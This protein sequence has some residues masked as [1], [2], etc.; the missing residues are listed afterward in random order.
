MIK[1]GISLE[2]ILCSYLFIEKLVISA[3]CLIG[4]EHSCTYRCAHGWRWIIASANQPA[5]QSLNYVLPFSGL[6]STI[7]LV[8]ATD[9]LIIRH[10]VD[11]NWRCIRLLQVKQLLEL[12]ELPLEA[13]VWEDN[14]PSL[15]SKLECF[16]EHHVFLLHEVCD[17]AT[18]AAAHASVTVDKNAALRYALLDEGNGGRKVPNQARARRVRDGDHFVLQVLRKERLD[19][20][21]DL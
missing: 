1:P 7:L 17:D 2:A 16:L 15:A 12:T 18:G 19:A 14:R 11:S 6:A 8:S 20:R 4:T 5:R 13:H 9:N 10:L 21:G 3:D